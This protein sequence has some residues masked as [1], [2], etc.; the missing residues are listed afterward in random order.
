MSAVPKAGG[1]G[2]GQGGAPVTSNPVI[3]PPPVRPGT[4]HD[5]ARPTARQAAYLV[6]GLARPDRRLPLFDDQGQAVSPEM[7]LV[8]LRRGWVEPW[9]FPKSRPQWFVCRLSAAGVRIARALASDRSADGLILGTIDQA[10]LTQLCGD[11]GSIHDRRCETAEEDGQMTEQTDRPQAAD[12]GAKPSMPI[13]FAYL[14]WYTAGDRSV[15]ADVLAIFRGQ[16]MLWI[17]MFDPDMADTEWVALA[18]SLKGSARGIGAFT[19]GDLAEQAEALIDGDH[20]ESRRGVLDAMRKAL[21]AV[22][23]EI[24]RMA[25]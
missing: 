22:Q 17:D 1:R 25:A 3:S 13:D 9:F 19:L 16:S 21:G 7:V 10:G 6:K 5:D 4:K 12:G 23:A 15:Q 14:D 11:D 24:D 18:H 2:S 8:C 20:R